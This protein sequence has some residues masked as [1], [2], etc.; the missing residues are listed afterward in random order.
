MTGFAIYVPNTDSLLNTGSPLKFSLRPMVD[1]Y[2]SPSE[3]L[4]FSEK[5]V[6]VTEVRTTVQNNLSSRQSDHK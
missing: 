2:P 5:I 1:G 6:Q 3:I 4:P